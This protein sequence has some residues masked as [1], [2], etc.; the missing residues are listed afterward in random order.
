MTRSRIAEQMELSTTPASIIYTN[1]SNKQT[2]L[3]PNVGGG[4]DHLYFFDASGNTVANL[5]LGSGLSITGTTINGT[6][7]SSWKPNVRV[8]TT[9]NGVL[10]TAF[11][12]GDT[13]DNIILATNDR[14]LIKN[15]FT[16]AENGIYV[17]NASGAPT[18]ATDN[19]IWAEMI[20]AA[21][22][23]SE[24]TVNGDTGWLCTA[25]TGGTI[26]VTTNTWFKGFSVAG[27]V[28]GTGAA[29]K[30]AY[31]LNG[32]DITSNTNFVFDGTALTVG[33]T[34]AATSAIIT[35]KGTGTGGATFTFVG[36]NSSGTE[37]FKVADN[38]TISI[39]NG[40]TAL[41]SNFGISNLTAAFSI[42]G[43]TASQSS[44][45]LNA[46]DADGGSS[47]TQGT[48]AG[49]T[50]A[51]LQVIGGVKNSTSTAQRNLSVIG[52]FSP[53]A[54]G[55]NT[56]HAAEINPVINQTTH[57]GI[58]RS[59]HISP[60]L[61]AAADHRV[62]ELNGNSSHYALYSNAG[63]W[64][65]NLGSDQTA[66]MYYRNAT[67]DFV[68]IATPPT[69]GQV[70]GSAGTPAIPTW[71][72]GG[73][74]GNIYTTDGSI[75]ASTARTLT[76]GNATS[77]LFFKDFTN[78]LPMLE[79]GDQYIELGAGN[80]T[81]SAST[82]AIGASVGTLSFGSTTIALT[83]N[84]GVSNTATI[85][86]NRATKVG[87]VYA[88]D[89][90]ASFTARSLVDKGYVDTAVGGATVSCTTAFIESSTATSVD[91]DLNVGEVKDKNGTN[92]AFTIPADVDKLFVFRNGYLQGEGAGRDYT[93]NTGTNTITFIPALVAT[94][95]V[96]LKK[97]D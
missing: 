74:A 95:S 47:I 7:V 60:T 70:L 69:A 86:D 76:L 68:R 45:Q 57:T 43:A 52:T 44:V 27:S 94:E 62:L 75:P 29:N 19:D 30:V 89:Y 87:I 56:F 25:N 48:P 8:A 67:G 11:E 53:S 13:I 54:G 37:Y 20:S 16:G 18:R 17:V 65:V 92:V 38:A 50:K 91:L 66:D 36:K 22:I 6:A 80:I 1:A 96:Q 41:F 4:V 85:T 3:A 51:T 24:G 71:V 46:N 84:N 10:A 63:K 21:V 78:N 64:K 33:D 58:T 49:N 34:A 42:S 31:W 12:N 88:N 61:T 32:T 28:S 97:I 79:F 14:I 2:Y 26:D 35:A 90:S 77:I 9:A 81:A 15:Q 73:V 93:L 59:L 23:V 39:T 82:S 5:T 40:S 55:T 83:I 72:T